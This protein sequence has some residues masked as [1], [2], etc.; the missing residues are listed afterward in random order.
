MYKVYF[1]NFHQF[2]DRYNGDGLFS[3]LCDVFLTAF[4][5]HL[6]FKCECSYFKRTYFK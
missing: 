4:Y 2:V 6:A 5:N 3:D 1:A